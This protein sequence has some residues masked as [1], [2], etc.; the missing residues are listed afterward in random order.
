MNLEAAACIG[1]NPLIFDAYTFPAAQTGIAICSTCTVVEECV[2]WVRPQKSFYDGVAAK[3]VW[4]NGYRVRPD[5][6]TREDR[7]I[8]IR[9]EKEGRADVL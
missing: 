6:S 2:E 4:R 9:K 7:I 3:I 5:N 1:M 8:R